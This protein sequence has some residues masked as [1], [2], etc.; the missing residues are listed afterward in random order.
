MNERRF[1]KIALALAS[2]IIL[3]SCTKA[4]LPKTERVPE[5]YLPTPHAVK[6]DILPLGTSAFTHAWSASY[7]D[8]QRTT[9]FRLELSAE[10]GKGQFTSQPD[11]DPTFLLESL[12]SA[13]KAKRIPRTVEHV[14]VLPFTLIVL[15]ENQKRQTDGSFSN[16]KGNWTPMKI[17]LGK[18][19]LYLNLNP[20]DAVAEFAMK[21]PADGDAVIAQLAKVL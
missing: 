8:G 16:E 6:F 13:L 9:H 18:A 15:G 5:P 14:D 20:I 19:E 17:T 10:T 4:P 12:Q 11:S 3:S 1:S 7:T 2:L 21:D